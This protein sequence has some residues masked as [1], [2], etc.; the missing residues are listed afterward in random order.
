MSSLPQDNPW[1]NNF[2]G[3]DA[4]YFVEKSITA[5]GM[6]EV[7]LATDIKLNQQVAIKVLKES[8]ATMAEMSERFKRE[9]AL[10]AALNSEHIVEILD[11]GATPEGY[12]FY[13]ME[14]L[15]GQ[16][17]GQLLRHEKRLSPKRAIEI[18]QQVCVGLQVAHNGV[19]VNG[20]RIRIVHR[21]LKPDNIFLVTSNLGELA[22]IID[23]GIAKKLRDGINEQGYTNLTQMFI[24]TFRYASPE[25]LAVRK[26]IDER[27]DLYSLGMIFYAML[28][29][30]DP[31]GFG[32][33]T[34]Q[35]SEVSWA[36]AHMSQ[37]PQSV[38]SQPGCEQFPLELDAIVL[39]CLQKLPK[40]RFSSMEEL[41]QALDTVMPL[42]ASLPTAK[43][44]PPKSA[45]GSEDETI[46]GRAILVNPTVDKP[47]Q[48]DAIAQTAQPEASP[49]SETIVQIPIAI[50]PAYAPTVFRPLVPSAEVE[51]TIVQAA[52]S[53]Q[54]EETIVQKRDA[55]H[56]DSPSQ[57]IFQEPPVQQ[58]PSQTI[59]QGTP[60]QQNPSQTIF[61]GTPVQQN[62]SQTIFQGTPVQQ[63]PSQTIFQGTPVQQN[64]SQTIFQG[65]PVQQNPAQ[66]NVQEQ[67]QSSVSG[68]LRVPSRIADTTRRLITF[69]R[70]RR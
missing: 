51:E 56:L 18:M 12:P 32:G 53:N 42:I 55:T 33:Q 31:F 5:G 21:D 64:P 3:E 44:T 23:F 30:T 40:N 38:R 62:P 8:L 22:K 14:Y 35:I 25:Q 67:I 41:K 68:L 1:I 39:K 11:S 10:C 27:A 47:V 69:I 70:Q 54:Q 29:G 61:Q 57:T 45:V 48:R 34:R 17:L 37:A 4:R 28:T 66:K 19:I 65:I 20:E 6:G 59:F 49:N 63:N 43:A 60:V 26:D 24:G 9:V 15:R 52:A 2:L 7:Y 36:R 58:N 46:P 50:N 13:V 16:S